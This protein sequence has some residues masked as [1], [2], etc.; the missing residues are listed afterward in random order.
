MRDNL[1][2]TL[3]AFAILL[4][5]IGHSIQYNIPQEFDSNYLFRLIY[6][7][8][9]PLFMFISGYVSIYSPDT[10]FNAIGRKAKTLLLPYLSWTIV[11]Y[12]I[13]HN[14]ISFYE[15]QKIVIARPDNSFWFLY[16]LFFI[17]LTLYLIN[18]IPSQKTTWI[19]LFISVPIMLLHF[20]SF[21][22]GLFKWYLFFFMIGRL[23][24]EYKSKI[25]LNNTLIL[26]TSIPLFLFLS[27]FWQRV[28]PLQIPFFTPI[29]SFIYS[30]LVPCMGI[31]ST[32]ALFRSI[33]VQSK[34][35]HKTIGMSTLEIY[36]TH[37]L[38]LLPCT[39][40][41]KDRMSIWLAILLT[42]VISLTC[43]LLLSKGI[44]QFGVLSLFLFGKGVRK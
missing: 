10:S 3:K 33:K 11:N 37:A 1:I 41:F 23:T 43:S 9:M 18:K 8:H 15:Y 5:I 21:G 42:I 34:H 40:F 4:V 32:F 30:L 29:S 6:S 35:W 19:G 2:D 27:Y 24:N 28:S 22:F 20:D 12:F 38:F 25:Q 26:I 13:F 17:H 7:F 31:V 36:C 39:Y 16:V 44:K 14:E